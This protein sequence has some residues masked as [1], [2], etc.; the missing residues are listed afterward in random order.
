MPFRVH[1]I[2]LLS[3]AYDAFILEEDGPLTDQLFSQYSELN[4]SQTPRITHVTTG[5]VALRLLDRRRF[6]LV[7]TVVRVE[8]THAD[9]LSRKIRATHPAMPI[10][11][12]IFDEA[13]LRQFP[14][15]R[16]PSTIDRT[17]RWTGDATILIAAIKLIE[18]QRNVEHDT[19]VSGVQVI[20]VVEDRM[21]S[22]S[23]F[24]AFLYPELLLQSQ[25]LIAEGVNELHRLVRMRARP[26]ILLARSY[27]EGEAL[28]V[29]YHDNLLTL[30]T[31][32]RF[33]KDG[34]ESPTAGLDLVRRVRSINADVPILML[35]SETAA[36]AD[37]EPLGVR[38][39]DK[40]SANFIAT[41]RHY[42]TD[43]LGF[44]DFIFKTKDGQEVGRARDVYEMEEVLGQVPAASIELHA[45]RNHFSRWLKARSMFGLAS[46]VR[47]TTIDEFETIESV[48]AYLINV[49]EEARYHEQE[50][51]ITD[52][53]P[54]QTGPQNRF[55]RVGKGS[56]G[57]K[58]RSIAFVSSLIVHHRLLNR[59]DG[60]EIRIPKTVV[61]GTDE[62]DRFCEDNE[63]ARRLDGDEDDR[64]ALGRVLECKLA[65]PLLRDLW[66]AFEGLKGPL[67]VRSSS[68]LEDSRYL[69]F[70]GIYATY[71]LPN[72]HEDPMERFDELCRAVV[73][74][75]GST[76]TKSARRYIAGT[77][78]M[79]EEEKMAVVIQQVV[80][81]PHGARF[82]PHISG[83]AKSY[84]YYAVA[85]Q[86][87]EDGIAEIALGMGH[88][89]VGGGAAVR[90]SPTR[91]D[92]LP[93]FSSA[94]SCLQ[95]AQT[96]F[97]ALNLAKPVVDFLDSPEASLALHDLSAAE[98][99]GTLALAGSVYSPA[100]D[101]IRDNLT[102]AGPRLVTFNNVLKWNAIPLA[103]ALASLLRVLR[104]GMGGEIEIEFA[105]DMG[106]WGRDTPYG[107]KR[108]VPR[109]YVLQ[110]R[111]MA[112]QEFHGPRVD[113]ASFADEGLLCRTSRALGDGVIDDIHDIIYV[114]GEHID[115][116][117][118]R[119]VARRVRELNAALTAA[120][121]RYL[122]IGPGRWGTSDP[123]LGVP[124]EWSDIAQARVIIET[125]FG[126][127]HV[128]PSQ[129]THFFQNIVALR[130]GYLTITSDAQ[131]FLDQQWLE[132]RALE[133]GRVQHIE[134]EQ[135][136]GVRLDG[137][138]GCAVI[139]K[140]V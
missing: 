4:L 34:V 64:T 69:P 11:L 90:F 31:D 17:V 87:P 88:I 6:D 44:G 76:F 122:L 21:Q 60:L 117:Q 94:Q 101:V 112:S 81:Q 91:P 111:P 7:I 24:L 114:R 104:D 77:P 2:L 126:D 118:T 78:H 83:V 22:Y 132:T 36:A 18:D 128:E 133:P 127:R 96:Q 68:L 33:P 61:L 57:G 119:E 9:E 30:I 121:R 71:M 106:D 116:T 135:P 42:L 108:R 43:S 82:Y 124:V 84:S 131:G 70:A 27:E 138:T 137:R 12:V 47:E 92:A 10:V 19:S 3:S 74:V 89:V 130:I 99:D 103:E 52:F 20:V 26:K 75:Y 65:S 113:L 115:G 51:V 15:A 38:I 93:Q 67:A 16:V 120:G 98:S 59:F 58:G 136:I 37:A 140:S 105:V 50:G 63:I 134:L 109:L 129:G 32:L 80:G 54:Q 45:S 110:V 23:T 40:R 55:V 73:A 49:L 5:S 97:F 39:V 46:M 1:E 102:T 100:D 139:I 29:K 35:T 28:C 86:K 107:R 62:Y 14:D 79:P 56:V 95:Q 53:S 25:S 41:V 48:R 13:D 8:D 85:G 123:S 125:S 66:S 72:N